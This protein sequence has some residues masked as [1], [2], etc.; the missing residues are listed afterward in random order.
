MKGEWREPWQFWSKV[1]RAPSGCWEW[2]GAKTSNGYG[3]GWNYLYPGAGGKRRVSAHRQSYVMAKGE[4]P[5]GLQIDHLCRNKKCVNPEHLE[6][7]TQQE[8][9]RRA[10]KTHCK[11]GH[12]FSEENT[13]IDPRG[14]RRCKAC[15][16]ER[17]RAF[18]AAHPEV[19]W[20]NAYRT[21]VRKKETKT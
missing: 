2:Q 1:E 4:I 3:D 15:G 21:P 8:N 13:A 16:R 12:P 20:G 6:A 5:E 14:G 11:H 10:A 9:M 18:Y 19:N 17:T 7:V